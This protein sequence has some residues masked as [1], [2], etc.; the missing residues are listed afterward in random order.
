MTLSEDGRK[1]ICRSRFPSA[2]RLHLPVTNLCGAEGAYVLEDRVCPPVFLVSE[3]GVVDPCLG[4]RA[5]SC[6]RTRMGLTAGVP[7]TTLHPALG[8]PRRRQLPSCVGPAA[9]SMRSRSCEDLLERFLAPPADDQDAAVCGRPRD[10][11]TDPRLARE[12]RVSA[13]HRPLER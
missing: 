13:P 4:T 9:D 1:A 12:A 10:R 3:V 6:P 2:T 11:A 8:Q 5:R 7:E